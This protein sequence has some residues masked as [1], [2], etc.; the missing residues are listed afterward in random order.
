MTDLVKLHD[1]T[2]STKT[3][4]V[5]DIPKNLD[6]SMPAKKLSLTEFIENNKDNINIKDS[7][8]LIESILFNLTESS[9]QCRI[10]IKNEE[11]IS[12]NTIFKDELFNYLGN[13]YKEVST[14]QVV[15]DIQIDPNI[16]IIFEDG[17]KHD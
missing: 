13:A 8:M 14:T 5:A 3:T 4:I 17:E 10:F 7:V 12:I 16:K 2:I 1:F 11:C 15:K 9:N 6:I